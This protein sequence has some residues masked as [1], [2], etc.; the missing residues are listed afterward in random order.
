M[1]AKYFLGAYWD[2]REESIEECAA[3]LVRFFADLRRCD[4][5]FSRWHETAYSKKKALEAIARTDSHQYW[6]ETL[7]RRRHWT[8]LPPKR[9]MEDL[10][11]SLGLWNGR[12]GADAVGLHIGC[13]LYCK[14][15]GNAVALDL[16]E[17]LGRLKDPNTMSAVLAAA[18]NAWE[19]D[20]A[21]VASDEAM[22]RR[23]FAA[24]RPFVDWMLYISDARL[25]N[26]PVLKAPASVQRLSGG[27]LIVVQPEPP[28]PENRAHLAHIK[29][30]RDALRR[31]VKTSVPVTIAHVERPS[32]V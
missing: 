19:P 21:C 29:Q 12:D 18:A 2:A 6:L 26:V 20:W 13:G 10:G 8:D 25:P 14:K 16:P 30:M 5:R 7:D 3:R 22:S 24:T 11:F 31:R 28:D 27:T 9:P 23:R 15:L 17:E 1:H 32:G 4:R